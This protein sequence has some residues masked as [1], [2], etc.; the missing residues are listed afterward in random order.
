MFL[1]LGKTRKII[2]FFSYYEN[3][4]LRCRNNLDNGKIPPN[5]VSQNKN[6]KYEEGCPCRKKLTEIIFRLPAQNVRP[7]GA[8]E[9][10]DAFL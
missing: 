5:G 4:A 9:T 8:Q 7:R 3:Y 6:T 1:L 10:Y 2:N